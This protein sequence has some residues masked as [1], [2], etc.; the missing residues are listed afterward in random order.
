M[1][2]LVKQNVDLPPSFLFFLIN[3]KEGSEK[4]ISHLLI[5]KLNKNKSVVK[6][7]IN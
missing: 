5:S 7:F 3:S 4:E 6:Y 1:K 2:E